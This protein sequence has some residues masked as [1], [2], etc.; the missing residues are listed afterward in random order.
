MKR[1]SDTF[2]ISTPIPPRR[3]AKTFKQVKMKLH[4]MTIKDIAKILGISASTVSRALKDHPDI[5]AETKEAVRRVAAS[6]NYRPNALA[7]SLRKAKTNI[8]GV[9]IPEM[10]HYFFSSVMSGMSETAAQRGYTTMMCQSCE[11]AEYERKELQS[12]MDSRVDGILLSVSKTTT[13]DT[14]L[15]AMVDDGMPLV[16]FDRIMPGVEVSRVTTDDFLGSYNAVRLMTS[17]GCKKI[18]I[19]CGD[20]GLQVSDHRRDGYAQA[21]RDAGIEFDP[22]LVIDADTPTKLRGAQTQLERIAPEIDGL[23][24][25]ND[26]TAVEAIKIL[27]RSGRRIPE[28]VEVV[29]FGNDPAADIIE[30]SLT[31]VEQNGYE[32]GCM[33]M[34][35]LIDQIESGLVVN[36]PISKVLEPKINERES[37][38]RQ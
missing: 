3:G 25:I 32:M 34:K 33:A 36:R 14:F 16:M 23:F 8:I 35:L 5:S 9:V 6:V 17:H 24:A 30:P 2:V 13:D 29:G 18:A 31:S 12:L 38:R 20:Q 21:L 10:S 11:N 1:N 27:K 4:Q 22:A 28:D 19:L 7:L 15:K 26:D 37:T